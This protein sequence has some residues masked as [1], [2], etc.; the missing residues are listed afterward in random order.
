MPRHKPDTIKLTPE[1][2]ERYQKLNLEINELKQKEH[3]TPGVLGELRALYKARNDLLKE[4]SNQQIKMES[5]EERDEANDDMEEVLSQ[6]FSNL[7]PNATSHNTTSHNATVHNTTGSRPSGPPRITKIPVSQKE[8]IEIVEQQVAT[9]L[10]NEVTTNFTTTVDVPKFGYAP[11]TEAINKSFKAKLG[12]K[13]FGSTE[14]C[15][16]S[17]EIILRQFKEFVEKH[18]LSKDAGE[19]LMMRVLT[20]KAQ[21]FFNTQVFMFK[22]R[23]DEIWNLLQNL[24]RSSTSPSEA[25]KMIEKLVTNP[26]DE[27]LSIILM[28]LLNACIMAHSDLS[29]SE[30]VHTACVVY[31]GKLLQLIKLN[32]GFEI[33]NNIV[34]E[35]NRIIRSN[36]SNG[37]MDLNDIND[38]TNIA[39]KIAGDMPMKRKRPVDSI[40]HQKEDKSREAKKV[41]NIQQDRCYNCNMKCDVNH[42][43]HHTKWINCPIYKDANGRGLKPNFN[44]QPCHNCGGKHD[45]VCRKRN[46]NGSSNGSASGYSNR[47][48]YN[49]YNNYNN[50]NNNQRYNNGNNYGQNNGYGNK[51]YYNNQQNN[52]GYQGNRYNGQNGYRPNNGFNNR[53]NAGNNQG[54]NQTPLGNDRNLGNNQ[55]QNQNF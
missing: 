5:I 4:A 46:G 40:K 50:S 47:N 3:Q 1:E 42:R 53:N 38:L 21:V 41:E 17:I 2:N 49:N 23:I 6:F 32:Y 25:M 52:Q 54:A 34:A 55:S 43:M 24:G 20:G 45:S 31:K 13:T 18:N 14:D 51:R 27:P 33:F 19:E 29:M 35:N 15:T 22:N 36:K 39:L 8:L 28:D 48:N 9:I 11:I 30:R 12:G 16:S 7:D 44:R 26:P 10:K 37:K